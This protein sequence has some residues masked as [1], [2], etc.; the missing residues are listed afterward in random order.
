MNKHKTEAIK[1]FI[2]GPN[3]CQAVLGSYAEELGLSAK[4]AKN[5][6]RPFG[7]GIVNTRNICGAASGMVMVLGLKYADE[8]EK[9]EFNSMVQKALL[10]FERLAGA[11]DCYSLTQVPFGEK[12]PPEHKHTCSKYIRIACDIID[13][14]E[15]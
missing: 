12:M 14:L 5:I 4:L 9:V 3:C 10:E 15:E 13:D 7:G 2:S 11:L 1:A 8:L 6:A